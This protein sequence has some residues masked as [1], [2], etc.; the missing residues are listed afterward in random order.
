MDLSSK[1]LAYCFC[2]PPLWTRF[3]AHLWT[4]VAGKQTP[5]C[6]FLLEQRS[7][8]QEVPSPGLTLQ[9]WPPWGCSSHSWDVDCHWS[10]PGGVWQFYLAMKKSLPC[11]WII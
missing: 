1:G 9:L 8:Q 4:M 7:R 5:L 6:R 2:L 3:A 11:W 10:S